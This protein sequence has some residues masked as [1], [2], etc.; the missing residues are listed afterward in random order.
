VRTML[1]KRS[2][3]CMVLEKVIALRRSQKACCAARFLESLSHC[4]VL[5]KHI[6][7]A[8]FL[9]LETAVSLE[10]L[11]KG[12]SKGG[13]TAVVTKGCLSMFLKKMSH[14]KGFTKLVSPQSPKK[15]VS[16]QVGKGGLTASSR[17]GHLTARFSKFS[18]TKTGTGYLTAKVLRRSSHCK[19]LKQVVWLPGSRKCCLTAKG[20]KSVI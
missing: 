3:Y 18:V 16:L 6:Y 5:E 8:R 2:S 17:E 14:C 12:S 15:V 13:L 4:D 1:S 9:V 7:A 19:V 10:S 11:P 20:L